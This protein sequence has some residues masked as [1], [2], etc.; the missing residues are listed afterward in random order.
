MKA[1]VFMQLLISFVD[2][3]ICAKLQIING[4]VSVPGAHPYQASLQRYGA[5]GYAHICG[6][7]IISSEWVLTAAHCTIDMTLGYY[8]VLAGVHNVTGDGQL[9]AIREIHQHPD[10]VDNQASGYPNDISLLRV[11]PFTM[12]TRVQ[13]LPLPSGNSN[14]AGLICTM[15]GWGVT[16][17]GSPSGGLRETSD[18]VLT[19]AQCQV[20][21]T[22]IDIRDEYHICVGIG[23]TGPC[24]GDSGGPLICRENGSSVL[25]GLASWAYASCS[26]F[27]FV[28]ARVS[29]YLPWICNTSGVC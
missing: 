28:Y 3:S 2:Q 23:D 10:Y 18:V 9:G 8:R 27:P 25:A 4:R 21:W 7:V 13:A 12:D 5:F 24:Q 6:G 19:G 17:S 22:G 26:E 15:T 29:S 11:E 14:F 1:L 20:G 16:E